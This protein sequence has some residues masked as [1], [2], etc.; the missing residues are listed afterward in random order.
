M[1]DPKELFPIAESTVT[2]GA[3]LSPHAVVDATTLVAA[4]RGILGFSFQNSSGQAVLPTLTS[5][6]KV[7]VDTEAFTGVPLKAKGELAA[8]SLSIALVTGAELTLALSKIYTGFGIQVSCRQ[9][10]LF[11]VIYIDD[12]SGTPV[13]TVIAEAIVGPGQYTF[14]SALPN[15]KLDTTAGTGVQKIQL[16]AKNFEIL[17]SLRG[18]ISVFE[19][20]AL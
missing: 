17:S 11:Q 4:L 14:H 8:G 20:N 19:Q 2:A 6:G 18:L 15:F 10:S 7:P 12:A 9:S 3:G 1:A 13:E 16:K 5:T